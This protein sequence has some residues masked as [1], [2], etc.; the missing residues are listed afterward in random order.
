MEGCRIDW[1]NDSVSI[2]KQS[3]NVPAAD[4]FDAR[5]QYFQGHNGAI[6]DLFLNVW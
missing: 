5:V 4:Q 3:G 6:H 1:R 2:D